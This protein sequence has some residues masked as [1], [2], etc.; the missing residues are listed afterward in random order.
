MI[1]DMVGIFTP[2]I[3]ANATIHGGFIF[4]FFHFENWL[5]NIYVHTSLLDHREVWYRDIEVGSPQKAAG[6]F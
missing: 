1:L 6:G 2:W 4:I 3:L 5:L